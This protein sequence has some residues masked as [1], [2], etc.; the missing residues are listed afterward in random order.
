M[1]FSA[2]AS[3][4]GATRGNET[5]VTQTDVDLVWGRNYSMGVVTADFS[6]HHSIIWSLDT[7]Q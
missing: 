7:G 5:D 3:R 4:A 1:D 2:A 6:F